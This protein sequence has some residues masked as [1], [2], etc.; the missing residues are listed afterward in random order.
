[1]VIVYLM[2]FSYSLGLGDIVVCDWL[3]VAVFCSL[4][5][6]LWFMVLLNCSFGF[7]CCCAC[8]KCVGCGLMLYLFGWFV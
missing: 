8:F 3:F 1:M 7:G 5:I 6:L 4:G 2:I